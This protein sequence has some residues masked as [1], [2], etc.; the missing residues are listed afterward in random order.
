MLSI[1]NLFS[2][3]LRSK[4]YFYWEEKK[5]FQLFYPCCLFQKCDLAIKEAY[6]F[7]NPFT[8]SKKFLRKKGEKEINVY[9]EI[10]LTSLL[11]IAQECKIMPHDHVFEL[12]C[13]RGRAAF[14]L[15]SFLCCRVTAV[16]FIPFFILKAQKI[17]EM[18]KMEHLTF[19]CDDIL[20][21]AL[22]DATCIYLY[23]TCLSDKLITQLC[24]SFLSLATKVKIIT[25]SYPLKDYHKE[26]EIIKQFTVAVPW[27][28]ID[29]FLNQKL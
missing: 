10:P 24:G 1:F 20:Q 16:D 21:V 4:I 17:V 14:F 2:I 13:G 15:R 19:I 9:G 5:V 3:Y 27:G 26:F 11:K 29:V 25:L 22:E 28:S 8:I 18:L 6:R 12:G 23:G 7:C